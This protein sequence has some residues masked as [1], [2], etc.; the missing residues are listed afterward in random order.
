MPASCCTISFSFEGVC[1][2]YLS[3]TQRATQRAAI[4]SFLQMEVYGKPYVRH[5]YIYIYV[6][7]Y[8]DAAETKL[9]SVGLTQARPSEIY[10]YGKVIIMKICM[11]L[12]W[13]CPVWYHTYMP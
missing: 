13:K 6:Y 5:I 2:E 10:A 11:Y 3:R 8:I 12:I 7:I 9:V 1:G 4:L